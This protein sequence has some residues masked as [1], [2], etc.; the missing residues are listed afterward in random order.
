MKKMTISL[1]EKGNERFSQIG[2]L[3]STELSVQLICRFNAILFKK[4][5]RIFLLKHDKMVVKFIWKNKNIGK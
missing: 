3:N 2:K 5:I 4:K 1:E